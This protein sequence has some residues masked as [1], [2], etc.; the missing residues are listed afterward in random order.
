MGTA[1][2]DDDAA[3]DPPEDEPGVH[4]AGYRLLHGI[5]LPAGT[6]AVNTALIVLPRPYRPGDEAESLAM[7]K[8]SLSVDV[9][10]LD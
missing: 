3:R 6:Y 8:Q 10:T 1:F 9:R 7:L 5:S 2:E 4:A